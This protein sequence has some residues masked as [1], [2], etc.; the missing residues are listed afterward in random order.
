MF[1]EQIKV[2]GTMVPHEIVSVKGDGSCLFR[3]IAHHVY[4]TEQMHSE[5]RYEIVE[6]VSDHWD[7]YAVMTY[8]AS[9]NG[10]NY[11]GKELYK[12]DMTRTEC[13]GRLCESVAA[14][15]LYPFLFEVYNNGMLLQA[16]GDNNNP[17]VRL[18]FS[19]QDLSNGHFDA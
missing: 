16:F 12:A 3:A 11:S 13:Y 18:L 8:D 4:G 14:G 5:V 6:F 10:D 9:S 19:G 1:F 17:V 7:S 15:N 2:N